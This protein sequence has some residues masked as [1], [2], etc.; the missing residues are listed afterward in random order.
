[1]TDAAFRARRART[2]VVVARRARV[3]AAGGIVDEPSR[4]HVGAVG[5]RAR[6]RLAGGGRRVARLGCPYEAA[7]A[8]SEA[9]DEEALREALARAPAA[10]RA[11]RS[12]ASS[13]DGSRE[14]GVR[15]VPRGPRRATARERRPR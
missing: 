5:A 2:P 3:L 8:L 11:A 12:R 9:D 4:T 6:G 13:R 14:R 10:G 7:L 1:M 15:D